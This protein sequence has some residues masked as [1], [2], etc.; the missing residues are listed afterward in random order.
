MDARKVLND[1]YEASKKDLPDIKI[2][3]FDSVPVSFQNEGTTG[4]LKHCVNHIRKN[5]GISYN[6]LDK[7]GSIVRKFLAFWIDPMVGQQNNIDDKF[8]IALLELFKLYKER[9]ALYNRINALEA[10]I[11][12]LESEA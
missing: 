1:R 6:C 10:K 9:E 7:K 12:K 3:P 8:T 2:E 5:R 11:C 4:S